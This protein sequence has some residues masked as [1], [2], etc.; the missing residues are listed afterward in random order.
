[1]PPPNEAL[2]LNQER[3][4]PPRHPRSVVVWRPGTAHVD[5]LPQLQRHTAEPAT[6][7]GHLP[8]D[9]P[10]VCL[11]AVPL[12]SV[13]IPARTERCNQSTALLSANQTVSQQI[14]PLTCPSLLLLPGHRSS[15]P[16]QRR[17]DGSAVLSWEHTWSTGWFWDCNTP[18]YLCSLS[19]RATPLRERM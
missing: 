1:M 7:G 15:H 5:V 4:A 2:N 10:G 16:P 9:L 3:C 6:T 19:R 11:I 14:S 18:P 12:D 8:D 17:R 13:M